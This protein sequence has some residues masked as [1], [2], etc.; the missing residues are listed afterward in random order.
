MAFKPG[1]SGNKRGRPTAGAE[2]ANVEELHRLWYD[3]GELA[4]IKAKVKSGVYSLRDMFIL[5]A[6]A[7]DASLLK[8]VMKRIHPETLNLDAQG[9]I[10][11]VV[12]NYALQGQGEKPGK[13]EEGI[14]AQEGQA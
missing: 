4:K 7:G 8:E 9:E 1:Q 11:V 2:K 10:K 12:T 3:D 5:K 14:P 6:A 13:Q